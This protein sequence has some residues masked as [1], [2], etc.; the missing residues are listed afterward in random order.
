LTL[1]RNITDDPPR[2]AGDSRLNTNIMNEKL[3][4]GFFLLGCVIMMAAYL[5]YNRIQRLEDLVSK[6]Q[7]TIELQ[8]TAIEWQRAE[9]NMLRMYRAR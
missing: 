8:K 9:N 2:L 5:G 4:I 1:L 7:D 3:T 6:Q